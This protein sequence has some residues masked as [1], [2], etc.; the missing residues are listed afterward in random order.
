M[1]VVVD[2]AVAGM[3]FDPCDSEI[4]QHWLEAA[5]VVGG[6]LHRKWF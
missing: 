3:I 2:A 4:G 6:Y 5:V 1:V